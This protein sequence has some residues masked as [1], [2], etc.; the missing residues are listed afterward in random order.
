V[1]QEDLLVASKHDADAKISRANTWCDCN[2]STY[3]QSPVGVYAPGGF[4]PV[5]SEDGVKKMRM[6]M[7]G[8][9][10][11]VQ[12]KPDESRSMSPSWGHPGLMRMMDYM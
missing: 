5:S 10:G 1:N 6:R 11:K 12:Q 7:T 3:N 4:S 8:D 9:Y 2:K